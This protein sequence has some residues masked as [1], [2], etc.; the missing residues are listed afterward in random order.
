VRSSL[1]ARSLP[2]TARPIAGTALAVPAFRRLWL[3]GL[4]SDAGDWTMFIAL[5]LVILDLTGSALGTSLAFLLELLPPV[6]LA[7][8]IARVADRL[9]HRQVMLVAMLAQAGTLAPLLTVHGSSDLHVVYGV[10]LAQA[11]FAAFVEPAKNALL[12]KLV[13]A[14][15]VTSANALIGLNNN[16]GRI[17]GGPLGGVLLAVGS[18][19]VVALVDIATYLVAAALV[20]SLPR[21][22]ATTSES[23]T[24]APVQNRSVPAQ[25]LPRRGGVLRAL[26]DPATRALVVIGMASSIAQGLFL[27]LFVFF[28]TDV[29]QGTAS[30]VGLLRGAQAVGAIIAGTVLGVLAARVNVLRATLTGVVTFAL[31]TAVT[32]N[33][34]FATHSIAV[35]AVLFAVMGAPAMLAGAGLTSLMQRAGDSAHHG[36]AFAALGLGQ[37][38]GQA[39]GLL[40]GGF[41]Q[42]S[43]GTLPLLQVQAGAHAAAAVLALILL[44]RTQQIAGTSHRE[45]FDDASSTGVAARSST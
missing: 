21:Q 34:S 24:S 31:V 25:A 28:V 45:K 15:Q 4:I 14:E 5:P 9:P 38:A 42:N 6:L 10:I 22:Q 8:L 18:I 29:I 27:V 33:L 2:R 39:V 26:S 11:T 16:L 12:P 43:I 17:I 3:A 13:A 19:S 41:L 7:P 30:D 40:S 36:S 35:Y 44:P 32:W 37:A 20:L 1:P 23:V